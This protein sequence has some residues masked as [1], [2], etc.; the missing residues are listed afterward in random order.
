MGVTG[1]VLKGNGEEMV[2]SR[3]MLRALGW[4]KTSLV[5]WYGI[6]WL[7]YRYEE[8]LGCLVAVVGG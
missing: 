5:Y 4:G 3:R 8:V 7:L 1:I 2:A 6:N